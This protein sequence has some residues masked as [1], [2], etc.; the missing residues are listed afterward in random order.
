M[1]EQVAAENNMSVEEV[2]RAF[3]LHSYE[4]HYRKTQMQE[5]TDRIN[6]RLRGDY[7]SPAWIASFRR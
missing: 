7:V 4:E 5:I 6:K 1:L 3:G 2:E